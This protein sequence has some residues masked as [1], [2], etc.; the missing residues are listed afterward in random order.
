MLA[1]D[2]GGT[3][4]RIADV[5]GG[6]ATN[7]QS[8][9]SPKDPYELVEKLG[10]LL[11]GVNYTVGMSVAGLID[12]KSGHFINL[13]SQGIVDFHFSETMFK[14]FGIRTILIHDCKAAALAEMSFGSAMSLKNFI[15]LTISTGVGGAFVLDGKV[16]NG[17][18]GL[19]GE[20]GHM[21]LV[22]DKLPCN[23]G[24]MGC[25]NVV[26]SG[27]YFSNQGLSAPEVFEA[28]RRGESEALKHTGWVAKW[29]GVGMANIINAFDPEAVIVGG[30]FIKSWD[31][32]WPTISLHLK[33]NLCLKRDPG[34]IVKVSGLGDD[35]CLIGAAINAGLP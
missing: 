31:V 2:Y 17:A 23:C 9:P 22:P 6:S 28:A 35:G 7:R 34:E 5:E 18:N 11:E 3:N 4:L 24:K 16:V 1:V 8:M 15:Y 14:K 10:R 13:T 26:A 20:I 25:W 32:L 19:A 21:S 27:L 29:N 30:S 12:S 33:E